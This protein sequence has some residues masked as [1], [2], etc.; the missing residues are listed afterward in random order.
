MAT[1]TM[2]LDATQS[3]VSPLS[4][5]DSNAS[6]DFVQDVTEMAERIDQ[7]L[8]MSLT[9][10]QYAMVQDLV[11]ATRIT[12]IARDADDEFQEPTAA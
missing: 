4:A 2:I 9:P 1:A 5:S 7:R 6:R 10:Q 11:L 8:R 12:T 3:T